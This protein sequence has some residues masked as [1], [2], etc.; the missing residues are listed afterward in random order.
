MR[1][2]EIGHAAAAHLVRAKDLGHLCVGGEVVLVVGVLQFVI[3]D[4]GPEER[5]DLRAGSFR[6]A[7]D[8][9]KLGTELLLGW[10][11]P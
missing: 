11:A 2:D 8:V 5:H 7:D 10:G 1:P 6:L 4:V 9:S 3:P